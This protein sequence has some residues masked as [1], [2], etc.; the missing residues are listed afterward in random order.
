VRPNNSAG[1]IKQPG[2]EVVVMRADADFYSIIDLKNKYAKLTL[3]GKSK[4]G[5]REVYV[6]D[7]KPV[8]GASDR[9]FVDAESYLPVRMNTAR[10]EIY[11]DDWRNADSLKLPHVITYT[12]QKHTMT[13]TVTEV[14][15][16]VPIDPKI[17]EKP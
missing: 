12:V 5:Y 14:K 8:S 6:I 3:V 9:L 1:I 11:F 10:A 16:N 13:L 2:G 4:I 7:M 17:F 15:Y